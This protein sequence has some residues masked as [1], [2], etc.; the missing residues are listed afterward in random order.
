MR[1][2]KT[3]VYFWRFIFRATITKFGLKVYDHISAILG[4][5]E[6]M[7]GGKEPTLIDSTVFAFMCHQLYLTSPQSPTILRPV[8]TEEKYQNLI[9]YT[10]RMKTKYWPDWEECKFKAIS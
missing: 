7:M 6:Y 3:S 5:N 8:L 4:D 2:M 10:E 1:P 9:K